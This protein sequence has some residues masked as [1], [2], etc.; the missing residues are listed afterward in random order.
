MQ[1]LAP[2]FYPQAIPNGIPWASVNTSQGRLGMP[3]TQAICFDFGFAS[4]RRDQR[5]D[6]LAGR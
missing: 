5:E 2:L 6:M 1:V 4:E 3:V